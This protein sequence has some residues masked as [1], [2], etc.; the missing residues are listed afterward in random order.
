MGAGVNLDSYK[1]KCFSN[2]VSQCSHGL[3]N[4]CSL[5]GGAIADSVEASKDFLVED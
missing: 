2:A 3:Q 4:Y 5:T 1:H